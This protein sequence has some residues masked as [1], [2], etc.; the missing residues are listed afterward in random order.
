MMAV[1]DTCILRDTLLWNFLCQFPVLFW[2]FFTP[3]AISDLTSCTCLHLLDFQ[4]IFTCCIC[5]FPALP[6]CVL[7]LWLILHV[8]KFSF[9]VRSCLLCVREFCSWL[10]A[11]FQ[12]NYCTSYI[13]VHPSLPPHDNI[14][15]SVHLISMFNL[16]AKMIPNYFAK[17]GKGYS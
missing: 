16:K 13:C 3:F 9:F 14:G 12:L 4:I 7:S 8:F 11:G 6:S 15:M 5:V 10:P 17:V 2:T 1:C